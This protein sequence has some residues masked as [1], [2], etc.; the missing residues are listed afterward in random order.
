MFYLTACILLSIQSIGCVEYESEEDDEVYQIYQK[1]QNIEVVQ[2]PMFIIDD[3]N[4]SNASITGTSQNRI[5]AIIA[6]GL[7]LLPWDNLKGKPIIC[8]TYLDEFAYISDDRYANLLALRNDLYFTIRKLSNG[9][10]I[11]RW[12]LENAGIE[13]YIANS[14]N[15]KYVTVFYDDDKT[16]HERTDK[17]V[18]FYGREYLYKYTA[19]TNE[20]SKIFTIAWKDNTPNPNK[21][22]V[23][24]CGKYIAAVGLNDGAWILVVNAEK[25]AK[26]WEKT[27][28][29]YSYINFND[30]CF[31]PDGEHIFVAANPGVVVYETKTGKVV[32]Q[33]LTSARC[34]GIEVSPNNR[35]VAAGTGP[36][37]EVYILD[38]KT[39]KYLLRLNTGQYTNYGLAFSPDS[40]MLATSGVRKTGIKI[41]QMP[42]LPKEVVNEPNKI[43]K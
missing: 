22:A 40:S 29:T 11:K 26:L 28:K 36:G 19:S 38:N 18:F 34:I 27:D 41:W 23:S 4:S 32:K 43:K 14:R 3:P 5:Q 24:E 33:W 13:T 21:I 7:F 39:D 42:D 37:G 12:M 31:S 20:F 35:L 9:Q 10:E 1:M 8:E 15:G 25:K 30:V 6:G 2:K 16:T 17:G